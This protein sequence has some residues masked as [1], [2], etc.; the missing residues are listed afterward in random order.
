ME[1]QQ[2]VEWLTAAKDAT[3][4]AR[5]A[6]RR[7][8]FPLVAF[9]LITLA[10][11]PFYGVTGHP[12][13]ISFVV[14]SGDFGGYVLYPQRL[15]MYWLLATI[16]GYLATV[17]YF[18]WRGGRSGVRS[19]MWPF[20]FTGLGLVALLVLDSPHWLAVLHI[21]ETWSPWGRFGDLYQRGLLPVLTIA[22]G[23]VVLAA[24]ER[25]WAFAAF[26]A[27]FLG[28]ALVVNL[29]D[30]GNMTARLGLGQHGVQAN[31]VVAGAVLLAGGIGFAAFGR[32]PS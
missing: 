18:R 1:H 8:W 30:L 16:V 31:V 3:R 15:A 10:A 26:A 17:V 29:Y 12:G 25:T 6:S 4:H 2:A 28:I 24:I 11:T 20:V 9:G 7:A 21:P 13:R 22:I 23:L 19:P 5:S 32:R 14:I 27:G